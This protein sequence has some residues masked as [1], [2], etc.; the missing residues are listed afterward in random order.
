MDK[1]NIFLINLP[2]KIVKRHLLSQ[3]NVFVVK[4]VLLPK[5]LKTY[6][7]KTSNMSK[8][9]LFITGIEVVEGPVCK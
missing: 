1:Y 5:T 6:E 2:F 8:R 9:L 7:C 4:T 3:A